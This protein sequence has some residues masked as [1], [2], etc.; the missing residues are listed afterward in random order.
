[1]P[2]AAKPRRRRAPPAPLDLRVAALIYDGLAAFE[3]GI[4]ADVFALRR[5]G[6]ESWYDFAAVPTEPGALRATGGI[7][8]TSDTP[9]SPRFEAL[10]AAGLIVVP[11]W[12]VAPRREPPGLIA[13]L[14]LAHARGAR[15]LSICSGSFLLARAGLLAG[16]RAT[17]HWRYLDALAAQHPDL[18]VERDVLYV[19][20]GG[21]L[22]SAGSAAGLDCCLH[23]VRRDFGVAI[24]NKVARSLVVPPMREGGQAQYVERPAPPAADRLSATLDWARARLDRQIALE[25]LAGRAGLSVRT[26]ARRFE[27]AT[28][29]SPGE[30]IVAERVGRARELLEEGGVSVDEAAAAVGL[31]VDALR[32]HFRARLGVS[33][34]RYRASFGAP[35]RG[36]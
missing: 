26:L 27:A 13:A 2:S 18:R 19:E 22:T 21:I 12:F 34:S 1:M 33:P 8:V 24:A 5:P 20:E 35:A 11:G 17:T 31:G 32:R 10:D 36:A 25:E 9:F 15:F 14:R 3:F 30:W 23:L 7:R 6:F 16:K 4:A 28:G 29:Q